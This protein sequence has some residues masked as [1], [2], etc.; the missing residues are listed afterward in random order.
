MDYKEIIKPF[1]R[2]SGY[3]VNIGLPYLEGAI[4]DYIKEYFLEL[5][6]DFQRGHI[7]TTEQQIAFV[8]FFLRGGKTSRVIYFNCPF[9]KN[10]DVEGYKKGKYDHPMV[11]VDGL[12]RLTALRKFIN[13]ELPIFGGYY[14]KDF[15]DWKVLLRK[16]SV[17]ININNL[18]TKKEVLKW[19]L[20][21]NNAGTP[22]TEE[23]L[24]RVQKMYEA[25]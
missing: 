10:G 12:Q 22:H 3:E 21:F 23:E 4:Q 9:F 6:P 16:E 13:N 15:E 8:E 25:L 20:E 5:N 7:W 24:N 2:E 17:R 18:R 11:C 1:T 14:L 19:Y